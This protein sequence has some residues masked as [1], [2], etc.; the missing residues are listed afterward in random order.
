MKNSIAILAGGRSRRM[1]KDK[2]LMQLDPN[3]PSLLKLVIEAVRP[4]TDDLFAVASGRPEYARFGAAVKPDLYPNAGALGGIGSA[5]R[6]ARGERTLVVSCDHP[7]LSRALLEAMLAWPGEWEALV[8]V[9]EGESRQGGGQI[10]QTLHAVYTKRCLPAIEA[11]IAAGRLQTAGI[12]REVQS[13]ELPVE[14][15]KAFD[16]ELR[17]LMS[18]NTPSE[19]DRARA[20]AFDALNSAT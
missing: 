18:I 14:A 11:A 9:V 7:Y 4:L 17:S 13:L 5:L 1:G 3:G 2:A 20:R 16:P 8:P 6:H 10:R 15:L 19:L 12:L